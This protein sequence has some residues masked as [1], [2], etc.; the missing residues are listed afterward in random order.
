MAR[1]LSGAHRKKLWMY[2]HRAFVLSDSALPQAVDLL[3]WAVDRYSAADAYDLGTALAELGGLQEQL[4]NFAGATQAYRQALRLNP[5]LDSA[6]L[7]LARSLLRGEGLRATGEV[8]NLEQR[9]LDGWNG[10]LVKASKIWSLIIAAC[11]AAESGDR[12]RASAH[13]R[14]A[15]RAIETLD[16]PSEVK[17]GVDLIPQELEVLNDLAANGRLCDGRHQGAAA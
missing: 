17:V 1:E 8:L 15:L 6:P 4:G 7:A 2:R 11:C 3:S 9:V 12:E 10:G 14:E 13:A 5:E 16:V